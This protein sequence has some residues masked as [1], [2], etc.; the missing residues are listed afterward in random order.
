MFTIP[1]AIVCVGATSKGE[2]SIRSWSHYHGA[3]LRRLWAL[4]LIAAATVETTGWWSVITANTPAFSQS[5]R[6]R[7]R[8]VTRP[9]M[10]IYH[11]NSLT[12]LFR[13]CDVTRACKWSC[14]ETHR[15]R[16]LPADFAPKCRCKARRKSPLSVYRSSPQST[17]KQKG[18]Q[19]GTKDEQRSGKATH[20][21]HG[22]FT[23]YRRALQWLM[24][25]MCVKL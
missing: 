11:C 10:I 9:P 22:K 2:T 15:L 4:M 24:Q 17:N 16:C 13:N 20:L 14:Q 23:G 18:G 6:Y 25:S 12:A 3:Q 19:S 5:A 1:R 8:W 21:G 7:W